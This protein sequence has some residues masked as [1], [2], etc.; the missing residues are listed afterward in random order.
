MIEPEEILNQLTISEAIIYCKAGERMKLPEWPVQ[1][2]IYEKNGMLFERYFD[3]D[4]QV[5]S[6]PKGHPWRAR[7]DWQRIEDE[8]REG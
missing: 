2:Y 1:R 3:S 8:V 4:K 7:N 6:L 5:M